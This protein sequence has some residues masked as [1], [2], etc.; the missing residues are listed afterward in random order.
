MEVVD[1]VIK[2]VLEIQ[3]TWFL[4]TFFPTYLL[5]YISNP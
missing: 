4:P 1:N 2:V 5:L 3:T